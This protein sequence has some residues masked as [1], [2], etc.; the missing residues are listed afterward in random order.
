[1]GAE[2]L[3]LAY[4]RVDLV[5][6]QVHRACKIVCPAAP[7]MQVAGARGVEQDGPGYVAAVIIPVLLLHGPTGQVRADGERRPHALGHVSIEVGDAQDE[8]VPIVAL[9]DGTPDRPSLRGIQL[10]RHRAVD[11]VHDLGNVAVEIIEQVAD[12]LFDG[13]C[14]KFRLDAHLRLLD[15]DKR[16]NISYNI[17]HILDK[18]NYQSYNTSRERVFARLPSRGGRCPPV[19]AAATGMRQAAPAGRLAIEARFPSA[20]NSYRR[21]GRPCRGAENRKWR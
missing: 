16:N 4:Y 8:L 21:E 20:H 7:A 14:L 10:C 5:V 19:R 15:F 18:C 17:N 11:E 13:C 9:L 3:A 12:R 6:A 1:M 2:R